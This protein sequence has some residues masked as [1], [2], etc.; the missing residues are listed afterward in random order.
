LG[1]A[2]I[3]H[4]AGALGTGIAAQLNNSDHN[5]KCPKIMCPASLRSEADSGKSLA[6]ATDVLIGVGAAAVI[7]GVVL[8]VFERR[9]AARPVA[10]AR[11][12]P[13]PHALS[14][15]F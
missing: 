3:G 4:L 15:W 10:Q 2:G 5:N 7:T 14:A 6:L 13:A 1:G 8:F 11:W 12:S 9:R